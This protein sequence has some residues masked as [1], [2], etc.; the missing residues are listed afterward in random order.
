MIRFVVTF[1]GRWVVRDEVLAVMSS[2]ETH[3]QSTRH[4]W[5]VTPGVRCLVFL[6]ADNIYVFFSRSEGRKMKEKYMYDIRPI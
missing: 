5:G 6:G 4:L 3:R 2:N 1:P